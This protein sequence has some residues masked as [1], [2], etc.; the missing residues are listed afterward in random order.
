[1]ILKL[2]NG[3]GSA[4]QYYELCIGHKRRCHVD[5]FTC[6]IK[7]WHAYTHTHTHTHKSIIIFSRCYFQLI[8]H[9][10][11]WKLDLGLLQVYR[12]NLN[13]CVCVVGLSPW[14]ATSM[15]HF[16]PTVNPIVDINLNHVYG[17]PKFDYIRFLD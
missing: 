2:Y 12:T 6:P 8:V 5:L 15:M 17:L 9:T 14:V 4:T 1:M 13:V 7:I 3:C 10:K 11:S 16:P